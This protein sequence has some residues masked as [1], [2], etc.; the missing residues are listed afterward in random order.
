MITKTGKK[1]RNI[2]DPFPF[3]FPTFFFC[4]FIGCEE[5]RERDRDRQ[6]IDIQT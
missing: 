3:F 6:E 2:W 1:K 5:E 4:F